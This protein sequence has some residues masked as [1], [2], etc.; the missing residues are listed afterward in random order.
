MTALEVF[1]PALAVLGFFIGVAPLLP[2]RPMWTRVLAIGVTQVCCAR[3]FWWRLTETEPAADGVQEI[4]FFLVLGIELCG[5]LSFS[6]YCLTVSR[7]IDRTAEADQWEAWLR[8]LPPEQVPE[9]DVFLPTYNEGLDVVERSI[10][11]ALALDYPRF[12]VWVLDDG[13]RDWLRDYCQAKGARYVRRPDNKHAKAG[14]INHALTISSAPLVA[15]LDADF[16]AQRNYLY[17]TVGLFY[18]DQRIAVVQTPQ[19][20]FNFDTFQTNL[21]LTAAIPDNEREWYDTMQPCRDA[22]DCAFCCGS[23]CVLRRDA[24]LAVGGVPTETITEDILITLAQFRLGYVTRYLNERLA[25]GLLPE[26]VNALLIQRQRWARGHLQ[27]L[28]LKSGPLGPGLTLLQRLLFLPVGY[29]L[30][31]LTSVG[32][33]FVVPLAFLALGLAPFQSVPAESLYSY[34]L[35]CVLAVVLLMRWVSPHTRLPWVAAAATI[36][37]NLRLFPTVLSTLVKPFGPPFRVTPKGTGNNLLS[38]DGPAFWITLAAAAL[39]ATG[40]LAHQ[41]FTSRAADRMNVVAG[42][43]M[44]SNMMILGLIALIVTDG[45]KPRV[46]ERFKVNEPAYCVTTRAERPCRVVDLSLSGAL[47]AEG[48]P[49]EVGESLELLMPDVGWLSGRVV[50]IAPG[51][52][53]VAWQEMPEETR[54]RLICYLYGSGRTNAVEDLRP[55]QALRAVFNRAFGAGPTR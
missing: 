26:N 37:L 18:S 20:F 39:T 19:H 3:Y 16:A 6:I 42:V 53:A 29:L 48:P 30:G 34:P 51:G 8:A 38:R 21:G 7:T 32:L 52:V 28:F 9:V 33:V 5:F 24:L 45:P 46:Q 23:C 14:N 27:M 50:R 35:P 36:Y 15:I 49:A 31:F 43:L 47:V 4:W 22:V 10:V 1:V 11:T 17:R 44:L 13:K 54:D 12:T 2:R 41:F 25:I 40:L 55:W